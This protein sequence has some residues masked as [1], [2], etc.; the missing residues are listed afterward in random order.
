MKELPH[1]DLTEEVLDQ[2]AGYLENDREYY[3]ECMDG[4]P[5]A[6]RHTYQEVRDGLIIFHHVYRFIRRPKES[7]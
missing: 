1:P 4:K 7:T 5:F 2:E 6:D 3:L